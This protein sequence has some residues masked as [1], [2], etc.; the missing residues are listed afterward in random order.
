MEPKNRT[1]EE[2]KQIR[3]EVAEKYQMVFPTPVLEPV[4]FGRRP[5][6]KIDG[7]YAIIDANNNNVFGVCTDAYQP[8]LHELIVRDVE[9]AAT[10]AKLGRADIKVTLLADGAKIK[11]SV[12]WP[13][14]DYAVRVGDIFHPNAEIKSSYDLQWKWWYDFG[15]F[16]LVCT[17]G[18]KTG[19][20]F[21]SF[22]KRHL[23]SLDPNILAESLAAGLAKFPEQTAIWQQWADTKIAL[24]EYETLWTQLPFS[25]TE[26]EKI[27][28]LSAT[29]SKFMISEAKKS[30][31]LNMWE[32][33]NI[34]TQYATHNVASELRQIDIGPK[35]T[36]AFEHIRF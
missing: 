9:E 34:M 19:E 30:N 26:R 10:L 24:P 3:A 25:T 29:G 14:V 16:R 36:R 6:N 11:V 21:E 5:T 8:I 33:Y 7:R 15:A 22:K 18:M 20:V 35:I 31:D 23:A 27:E 32:T 13:E 2:I 17:N 28:A 4:W 1:P 12:M